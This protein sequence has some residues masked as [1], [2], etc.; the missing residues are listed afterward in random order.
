V[1]LPALKQLG[2]SGRARAISAVSG[3]ATWL[4][5]RILE[6]MD[7]LHRV[8]YATT[9]NKGVLATHRQNIQTANDITRCGLATRPATVSAP[10][11]VP[12]P[13]YG[14][15]LRG[16]SFIHYDSPTGFIV[17]LPE[18]L[19][20]ARATD[21][22]SLAT[23]QA[24]RRVIKGFADIASGARKGVGYLAG[25]FVHEIVQTVARSG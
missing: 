17:Q 4:V 15:R 19:G 12:F 23:S 2:F 21:L 7:P 14:T 10:V 1:T 11:L 6:G 13:A 8:G 18:Q 16:I 24:L 20:I 22:L 9:R 5:A 25:G 3:R